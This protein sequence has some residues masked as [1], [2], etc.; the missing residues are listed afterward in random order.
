MHLGSKIGRPVRIDQ[1]TLQ[2]VRGR[3]AHI[4]MCGGGFIKAVIVEILIA[5]KGEAS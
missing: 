2:M 5:T 3:F 4:Y 1:N